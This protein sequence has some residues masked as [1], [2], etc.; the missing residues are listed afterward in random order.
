MKKLIN[1]PSAVVAESLSGF[2]SAYGRLYEKVDGVNGIYVK[3]KRPKVAIVTGGGS[4]HEPAFLGL[5]GEGMADGVALGNVFASP[6]PQT[7]LQTIKA[8]D[9]GKGA[10]LM[11]LNYAG[12]TMNFSLASE[13]AEE[14]G[15]TTATV[16]MHDDI[17]SAPLESQGERRGVAGA[18]LMLKIAGAAA[19][20]GY[21]LDNTR[22]IAEKAAEN[23]RSIG[24]ALTPCSIPGS[25]ANFSIPN[26]EIEYGMG[27]HGE[28]GIRREKLKTADEIAAQMVADLLQDFGS[29]CGEEIV[30]MINGSGATTLLE[31]NILN[32]T[33][34]QLLQEAG[35][36]IY[37]NTIGSCCTSLEMAGAAVSVLKL[38]PELK[39]LYDQPA[40]TP[41]YYK[42]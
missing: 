4:G 24:I 2:L 12:D 13:L 21:D 26:D 9:R 23:T 8:A 34:V 33:T 6:D 19:A 18:L 27:I 37:D 42:R 16:L 29:L 14:S 28:P 38:D 31:L 10:L 25:R 3:D 20:L 17:A 35:A 32:H 36:K 15:L 7:I 22:R 11:V 30:L 40:Y 1:H 39:K 41:Y 5:A